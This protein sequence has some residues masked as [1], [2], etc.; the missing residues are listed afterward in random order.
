MG[1][2]EDT[3]GFGKHTYSAGDGMGFLAFGEWIFGVL[4]GFVRDNFRIEGVN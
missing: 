1:P 4:G 3:S 2:V